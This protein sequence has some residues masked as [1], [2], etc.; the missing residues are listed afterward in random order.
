MTQ[1]YLKVKEVLGVT[2]VR[3]KVLLMCLISAGML[4]GCQA[5]KPDLHMR[6]QVSPRVNLDAAQQGTALPIRIY[7]LRHA[8]T[9]YLCSEQT[10][11]QHDRT[12]LGDALL[13]RQSL[14]L[15]PGQSL[16]WQQAWHAN[17]RAIGVVAFYRQPGRGSHK[18]VLPVQLWR[19]WLP[20]SYRLQAGQTG[21]S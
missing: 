4:W 6:W 15:L 20:I 18:R 2:A 21:L 19:H 7:Q 1:F 5:L 8:N 12:C 11:W 16:R 13:S 10:L 17:T 9:W 14:L 3:M